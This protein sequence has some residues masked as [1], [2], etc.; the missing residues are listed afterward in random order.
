[1]RGRTPRAARDVRATARAWTGSSREVG[2]PSATRVGA[3]STADGF[4]RRPAAHELL[5]AAVARLAEHRVQLD[6]RRVA[7]GRRRRARAP[8]PSRGRGAGRR[9]SRCRC[10]RRRCRAPG[11]AKSAISK[12]V[13]WNGSSCDRERV[14][15]SP[16][17][18][19]LEGRRGRRGPVGHRL[20]GDRRRRPRR[21]CARAAAAS[22][23]GPREQFRPTIAAPCVGQDAAR[24]DVVVAVVGRR[25]LHAG[26]RH[27]RRQPEL[28]ADLEADQ[29]LADD[30]R[31][32]RR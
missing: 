11:A 13:H 12:R 32:S 20:R 1:M 18:E 6:G 4:A 30:S 29:R 9:R 22:S 31:W 16:R 23:A 2:P 28:L 15:P 5:R 26:E 10:S 3:R 7:A 25:R 14:P 24:L 8:R 21:G 27:H 17:L 19:R